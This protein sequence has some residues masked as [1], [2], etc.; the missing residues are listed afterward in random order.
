MPVAS[1]GIARNCPEDFDLDAFFDEQ[2][3]CTDLAPAVSERCNKSN[4]I[5][6]LTCCF[7]NGT[8]TVPGALAPGA[9]DAC[10]VGDTAGSGIMIAAGTTHP[11]TNNSA[12]VAADANA[13]RNNNNWFALDFDSDDFFDQFLGNP[14]APAMAA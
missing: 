2:L 1:H 7:P 9:T 10:V 6:S 4:I 5:E 3:S 12:V 14:P 8:S 11:A 13:V